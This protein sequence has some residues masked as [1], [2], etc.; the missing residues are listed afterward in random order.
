M[1]TIAALPRCRAELTCRQSSTGRDNTRGFG[2]HQRPTKPIT[3]ALHLRLDQ[4]SNSLLPIDCPSRRAN[5]SRAYT[6]GP[7]AADKSP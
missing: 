1:T 5:R 3:A 4:Q 6:R 2:Q 7:V